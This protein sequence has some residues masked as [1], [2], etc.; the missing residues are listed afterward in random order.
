[1]LLAAGSCASRP[2]YRPVATIKDIMDGLVDP[3]AGDL[4]NSVSTT[5]DANGI[6]ER[7]PKT[8]EE[9]KKV[10][11]NALTLVEAPNLLMMS[12]KVAAPGSKYENPGIEL[13]PEEIQKLVDG[14]R[15][16]FGRLALCLQETALEALKAI[17]A[18][19]KDRLSD[20]GGAID[21][22]CEQCHLRYWYPNEAK[23]KATEDAGKG[24]LYSEPQVPPRGDK[25]KSDKV[26]PED[27]PKV[28]DKAAE[29]D[30]KKTDKPEKK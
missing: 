2:D 4:W 9:W 27:K 1:M 22:A 30:A 12:R 3:S 7:Y 19:D 25:G 18:K 29:K 21:H 8:D 20:V 23:G 10:R 26:V 28:E 11:G 14:D 6:T 5:I 13:T 24:C 15:A 17:D 16:T